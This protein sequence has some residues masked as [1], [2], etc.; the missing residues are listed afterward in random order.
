M[1]VD[2]SFRKIVIASTIIHFFSI[3][4]VLG[5]SV[6]SFKK[7]KETKV[8]RVKLVEASKLEKP[9]IESV[10]KVSKEVLPKKEKVIKKKA[11][12]EKS[13]ELSKPEDSIAKKSE[14]IKSLGQT[15]PSVEEKVKEK[16]GDIPSWYIDLIRERIYRLWQCPPGLEVRE[17]V[18]T[19]EIQRDGT[20]FNALVE[21]SSG[22]A[23]FDE[24]ALLTIGK[25]GQ[26][27]PL[28]DD[29]KNEKLVVHFT[30]RREG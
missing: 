15:E 3:M 24:S 14:I 30:F 7:V 12:I 19:F 13:K 17:A 16:A 26:F 20:V 4:G 5:F 23:S 22:T 8:Y 2:T 28:P 10:K 11:V 6:I 27:H 25:I 1:Q 21:S 29:F 9:R 18:I